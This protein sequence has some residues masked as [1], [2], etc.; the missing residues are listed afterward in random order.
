MKLPQRNAKLLLPRQQQTQ[1][2]QP[3]LFDPLL[4]LLIKRFRNHLPLPLL[5]LNHPTPL[6]PLSTRGYLS[7]T[8]SFITRRNTVT[9]FVCP[10]R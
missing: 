10:R 5:N 9:R 3:R 2:R 1:I 8:E 6:A 7:S 4:L